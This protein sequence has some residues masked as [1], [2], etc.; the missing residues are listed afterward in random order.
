M[1]ATKLY[2]HSISQTLPYEEI[3]MWHGHP[4]LFKIN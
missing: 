4:D 3:K 2:G 1:D